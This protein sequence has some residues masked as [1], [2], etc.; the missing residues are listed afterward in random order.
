LDS[1]DGGQLSPR[2]SDEEE[3]EKEHPTISNYELSKVIEQA[4]SQLGS[5]N[6]DFHE[7]RRFDPVSKVVDILLAEKSVKQSY[8]ELLSVKDGLDNAIKVLSEARHHEF[9]DIIYAIEPVEMQLDQLQS[10][11]QELTKSSDII[12]KE[13]EQ[14]NGN[15]IPLLKTEE[16]S[17]EY[18]SL[19][20]QGLQIF[21]KVA[22]HLEEIDFLQKQRNYLGASEQLRLLQQEIQDRRTVKMLQECDMVEKVLHRVQVQRSELE[23]QIFEGICDFLFHRRANS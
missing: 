12:R 8:K 23:H 5:E 13:L 19:V 6:G 22:R 10:F 15:L 20:T 21:E 18:Y 14:K 9:N 7:N 1:L 11:V 4:L 3:E 17:S 2:D 16:F